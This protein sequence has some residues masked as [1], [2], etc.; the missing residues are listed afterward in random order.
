MLKKLVCLG[1]ALV[2]LFSLVACENNEEENMEPFY[3]L[4]E[5]YDK[6]FLTRKDLRSIAYYY[7]LTVVDG[8][9]NNDENFVPK[10]KT[11]ET[12]NQE[13]EK[14]IKQAYFDNLIELRPDTE[15]TIENILLRHYYGTYGECVTVKVSDNFYMYDFLF[16][17][18]QYIGGV[19]FRNYCA[20]L[21]N[22][23]IVK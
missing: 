7:S 3:T 6:G 1:I 16:I 23:W 13:T 18:E 10:P 21:V 15:A 19:L 5:A 2:M 11:P 12:L 14:R 9:S 20:A 4:Q 8:G 22:V 17:T